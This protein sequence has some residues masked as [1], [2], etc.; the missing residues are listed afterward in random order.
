MIDERAKK[1]RLLILDVDGVLTDGRI[2]Y[3]N[4]GDELK[5]FNVHDGFGMSLLYKAGI[6]SVIITA[7]KTRIV[8]RRAGDMHI[9][10]LYSS[11]KK[12]SVYRKVLKRFSVKHEEVCYMGDDLM[13]LP[14]MKKVGFAVAPPN[15]I[16]EVKNSSHYITRKE[17]GQGAVREIIDII[18]KS[19]G[20]WDKAISSYQG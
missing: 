8:K 18:L 2:I 17:G 15:A 6:K 10:A 20:L 12:L 1:V 14:V 4:F 5:F 13:D 16:E 7:K 19:Q 11:Y 3:D 9:A